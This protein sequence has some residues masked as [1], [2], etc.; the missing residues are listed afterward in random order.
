MSILRLL[1]E[2]GTMSRSL[3]LLHGPSSSVSATL[4]TSTLY[5]SICVLADEF[6]NRVIL[7]KAL[8]SP[9]SAG[10]TATEL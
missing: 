1:R 5:S 9:K 6:S 7:P 3:E 4:F 10:Q 8:S 2:T